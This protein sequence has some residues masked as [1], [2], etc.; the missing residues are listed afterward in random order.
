MENCDV[1]QS[2]GFTK[3]IF[4]LKHTDVPQLIQCLVIHTCIYERKAELILGLKEAGVLEMICQH[5]NLF[6]PET[7]INYV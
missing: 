1:I 5:L 4:P 7:F 2:C 6:F 3:P